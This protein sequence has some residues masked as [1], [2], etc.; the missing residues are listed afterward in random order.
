MGGN[1]ALEGFP[2]G[3]QV[4][5]DAWRGRLWAVCPLCARWNLS[6]MEE[7]WE[8]VE[9]AEKLFRD[10]RLK[11]QSENIGLAKLPDGTRLVRVGKAVP[12][13]LAAWRYGG[14]LRRRRRRYVVATGVSSLAAAGVYGG[15]AMTGIGSAGL[16]GLY[17][18]VQ[19]KINGRIV[20]RVTPADGA[21]GR[22]LVIRRWHVPGMHLEAT[23][24]GGLAVVVRDVSRKEPGWRGDVNRR[25]KDVA[26]ITG[27]QAHAL[28][29][30]S[31][32]RVNR[33]G[34][35]RDLLKEAD[36]ILAE[37]GSADRIIREA[38]IG[39]AALGKRAG[40]DPRVLKG[41]A[42]LAFEMALNE[43][44]E[45]HALEGELAALEQAWKEAE[46]IAAIADSLPGGA[47]V[48]RLLAKLGA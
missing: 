3:S 6:P 16:F 25:S 38:A 17:G 20:H 36:R 32:V 45:R 4:A 42:A 12:G 48:N 37:A 15:M 30:R 31:M 1:D 22:E 18:F 39:G 11:V 33:S 13:E 40:S 29:A 19:S 41:P 2:V 26:I 35:T 24:A 21:D 44:A 47:L 34:A 8:P 43:T 5:F 46:E 14:Q 23:P 27:E 7:R 9:A 10:A 28:L